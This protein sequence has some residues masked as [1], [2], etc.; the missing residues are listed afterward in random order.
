MSEHREGFAGGLAWAVLGVVSG[1]LV[2]APPAADADAA[3]VLAYF[4]GNSAH[5]VVASVISAVAALLL[6]PFFVSLADRMADQWAANLARTAGTVVVTV[7]LFG[8][9]LQAGLARSAASLGASPTLLAAFMIDR[10]AFF[11]T[12]PLAMS[13]ILFAA[14][15]GLRRPLAPRWL[16]AL[17]GVVGLAVL[18]GGIA[19]VVSTSRTVTSAGFGGFVLTVVWVAAAS[20]TLLRPSM[21]R[22]LSIQTAVTASAASTA[23]TVST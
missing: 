21:D 11:V 15:I 10:A 20:V 17:A 23:S 8:G 18:V 9:L 7:G 3:T 14:F 12:P 19:G 1:V 6:V 5:L 2:P 13:V 22:R 4:T 16:G